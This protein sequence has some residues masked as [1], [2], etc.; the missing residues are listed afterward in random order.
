ML[1][2]DLK[3][4]DLFAQEHVRLMKKGEKQD[5]ILTEVKNLKQ[6]FQEQTERM[7]KNG[8]VLKTLNQYNFDSSLP[9]IYGITPTYKR[10]TQKADLTRLCQTVLHV[11]NFHWIIVEDSKWKTSL[12]ERFLTRCGV[13]STHLA[14]KTRA[15]LVRGENEPRWLK[16][17]GVEQRNAGLS[18]LR[19]NINPKDTK[20][21]VYFMDDD[22]TYD[23]EIFE[24]V[25]NK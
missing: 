22:N 3:I 9:F 17:R 20:G 6:I 18:W 5:E 12:V 21:V 8:A 2:R 19:H 16:A 1:D 13:R 10:L 24:Q 15:S 11:P 14:V 7:T 4:R 23:P 25:S